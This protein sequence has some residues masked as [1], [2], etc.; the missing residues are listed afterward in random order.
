MRLVIQMEQRLYREG[1]AQLL[2]GQS[3]IT[4]V[5]AVCGRAE[6]VTVCH[7]ADPDVLVIEVVGDGEAGTDVSS[8]ARMVAAVRRRRPSVRV[9]AV[10]DD[11]AARAL[12]DAEVEG[13][14]LSGVIGRGDGVRGVL[15]AIRRAVSTPVAVVLASSETS[16]GGREEKAVLTRREV[17]VLRLI[18]RGF[19]TRDMAGALAISPKTIE[20]HKQRMFAKL[21]VQNQAHAVGLAL[22]TGLLGAETGLAPGRHGAYG[23]HRAVVGL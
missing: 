14:G 3:D 20:N 10:C 2:D 11:E 18:G 4:V 15:R 9:V 21:G 12:S 23:V 6:T 13:A 8:I 19:T 16:S 5:G 17:D 1:L 7:D 22:R